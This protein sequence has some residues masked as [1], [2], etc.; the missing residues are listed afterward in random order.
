MALAREWIETNGRGSYAM[1]TVAGGH[2]RRYHGLLTAA[3][4]PPVDRRQWVNLQAEGCKVLESFRL[5]PWPTWVYAWEGGR[6]EK[7]VF[8]RYGE[9]TAV[10]TYRWLSGAASALEAR[11]LITDRDPHFLGRSDGRFD[12]KTRAIERGARVE[13]ASGRVRVVT[14][15]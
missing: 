10:V 15:P 6:V 13:G 1:G 12:G 3:R 9:D 14:L 8:L 11:P 2:T 7:S 5:D 4:R